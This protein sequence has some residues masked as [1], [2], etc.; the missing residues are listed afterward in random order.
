MSAEPTSS[1][2]PP[3]HARQ[4]GRG[5]GRGRGGGRG[6]HPNPNGGG[7][8]N[9]N[10]GG[11]SNPN[12]NPTPGAGARRSRGGRQFGSQL[13]TDDKP[14]STVQAPVTQPHEIHKPSIKSDPVNSTNGL[15]IDLKS[16]GKSKIVDT[17]AE[18]EPD[19]AEICFICAQPVQHYALGV[20]SHRTCHVCAI[21]MR[22]LYNKRECTFCKT[23]LP[24]MII[25]EDS[26]APYGTYDLASFQY[27]DSKLSIFCETFQQLE[28]LLGLLKFN[29]PHPQCSIV[30]TNWRE[31]K[32]H[33]TSSHGLSL[34]DLCCT[35]KKV[36]A[37]EHTL[38]T[39]DG[40]VKHK[41]IGSVGTG[42]GFLATQAEGEGHSL[43]GDDG[44]K[45]HP[46]C[47]FCS[48][49]FYGDDELYKHCREKHEQ[50]F[51]CAAHFRTDHHICTHSGCLQDKFVVFETAFELQSHLVE[52][53]GAEMGTKAIKD[54]RKI[55]TNFVYSTSREQHA[56]GSFHG[57]AGPSDQENL[58]AMSI[59]PVVIGT[60]TNLSNA[61]R[62]VPGLG[63]NSRDPVG[64]S[65]RREKS[66]FKSTLTTDSVQD[67]QSP[68]GQVTGPEEVDHTLSSS[69]DVVER[70]KHAALMQKV[71][72]A[73]GGSENKVVSFRSAVKTYLNNEM[74]VSGF[75]DVLSTIF[76][77][78]SEAL[79]GIING[80]L[81]LEMDQDRKTE[82]LKAWKDL[83]AIKTQFPSLD[84]AG[85]S[86]AAQ[87][88]YSNPNMRVATTW[89]RGDTSMSQ[90]P[91]PG[92]SKNET[93]KTNPPGR[94]VPGMTPRTAK[95]GIRPTPW[96]GA[97]SASSS[98]N[99]IPRVTQSRPPNQ[100]TKSSTQIQQTK[101]IQKPTEA[102][103]PGLPINH[104]I[105]NRQTKVKQMLESNSSNG[106]S[107]TIIDQPFSPNGEDR[108]GTGW[109]NRRA[110]S[111]T[112]STS[113]TP[114]LPQ[115]SS[116][117]KPP[118]KVVLFTNARPA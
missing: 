114:P 107:T 83:Q 93:V 13:T 63:N 28:E 72:D 12:P 76:E 81:N 5:R 1:V 35:N 109:I 57:R 16:K 39:R 31:L 58:Q 70:Q 7:H 11:R 97:N 23:D 96:S 90:F 87:A 18:V 113:P 8:P 44:F 59:S 26:S 66:K 115:T 77:G 117:K 10:G 60:A 51:I 110:E 79:G 4:P 85:S 14:P 56:Q 33:T 112:S 53:H 2:Q 49:H 105:L 27:K 67:G 21:K 69:A 75:L 24:E 84:H 118:K 48:T 47:E 101:P 78:R 64:T 108:L 80:L 54:A 91:L 103:F 106:R 30:L 34:C 65:R 62:I 40:L 74:S 95:P 98:S 46:K 89:T 9:P 104:A 38:F 50:C 100:P 68:S 55:E 111:S 116:G 22:A 17:P 71:K 32:S 73:A 29:C 45:G 19:E 15:E 20:C 82:L 42:K 25:T 3:Q 6:G 86:R 43:V 41:N 61:N 99:H 92:R 94:E 37:H 88:S 52:K 102:N 36:F